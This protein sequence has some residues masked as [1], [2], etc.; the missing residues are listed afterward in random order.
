M[1]LD[2]SALRRGPPAQPGSDARPEAVAGP[3]LRIPDRCPG[4]PWE[5]AGAAAALTGGT[6]EDEG[7]VQPDPG[8]IAARGIG[9]HTAA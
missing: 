9:L 3:R 1:G 5:R 6:A 2:G 4:S 8:F 7:L